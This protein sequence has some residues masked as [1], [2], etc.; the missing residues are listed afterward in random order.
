MKIRNN[1]CPFC[2]I[3]TGQLWVWANGNQSWSSQI[4]KDAK[5]HMTSIWLRRDNFLACLT[6]TKTIKMGSYQLRKSNIWWAATR[7]EVRI[8]TIRAELWLCLNRWQPAST[9][10]RM[11][12]RMWISLTPC[13]TSKFWMVL[14]RIRQ[15][16]QTTLWVLSRETTKT[17]CQTGSLRAKMWALCKRA[18]SCTKQTWCKF[19]YNWNKIPRTSTSSSRVFIQV[20]NHE[21]K[22]NNISIIPRLPPLFRCP[23]TTWSIW[24]RLKAVWAR[25]IST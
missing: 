2:S 10:D 3:M 18:Q 13:Q 20:S 22:S 6:T 4:E 15:A 19:S 14:S 9:L 5:R 21:C 25:K 17:S 24:R 1:A 7:M 11:G 16:Q 8:C 23:W 12:F